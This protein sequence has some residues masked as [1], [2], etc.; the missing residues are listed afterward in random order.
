M[1]AV[2]VVVA[3]LAVGATAPRLPAASTLLAMPAI[4]WQ[5]SA[6]G[7][8]QLPFRPY[9]VLTFDAQGR[10]TVFAKHTKAGG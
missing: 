1:R 2:P 7:M 6:P 3:M 4:G 8:D 9:D 5:A 10:T